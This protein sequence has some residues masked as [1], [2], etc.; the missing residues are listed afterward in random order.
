MKNGFAVVFAVCLA[1]GASW[2]GFVVAPAIQLGG[3]PQTL[4]LNTSDLFPPQRTGD[5][6]LGL[7]VYRA[8]GCA[9]CHTEQV[10]QSG[11]ACDVILTDNG[12]NP[13]AVYQACGASGMVREYRAWPV[14]LPITVV[15]G[16]NKESAD[17]AVDKITT[18][19]GKAEIHIIATGSD[20]A[21]GWGR[22]H[23]VAED[24]LYDSPVQLGSLRIGQDL[25]DVGARLPDANWQL[26]HL[27]APQS[28]VPGSA[29]PPF[30]YLFQVRKIGPVPSPDALNLPKEFAPPSGY[31][32]VPLRD[33]PFTQP[34]AVSKP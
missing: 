6:T 30:R 23:S 14:R 12:K 16:V 11:V 20:I 22:R 24:Y 15:Q 4:V 27:Y 33:A 1:L 34:L 32:V 3:L 28:M 19:G 26:I 9:A 17:D 31:E 5:A 21:R 29:M 2:M 7:Q 8:N 13:S 10:Q 25:A 18:A